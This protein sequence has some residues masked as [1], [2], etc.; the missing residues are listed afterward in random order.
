[1]LESMTLFN[2]GGC[3]LYQYSADPS[4]IK[5]S[6]GSDSATF[7]QQCIQSVVIEPLVLSPDPKT[8]HI[9]NGMTVYWKQETMDHPSMKVYAVAIYPDIL[10]EGPR[11][12][13]KN[14]ANHLLQQTLHEYALYYQ[15][16]YKSHDEDI[17]R[18]DPTLFDPTFCALLLQSKT[19][20]LPANG[21]TETSTTDAPP[22]P[23]ATSATTSKKNEKTQRHWH[24]GKAVVTEKAMAALDKSEDTAGSAEQSHERALREARAAYLPSTEELQQP[25]AATAA[26]PVTLTQQSWI[27]SLFQHVRGTRVIAASDLQQP[28]E[29]M[30]NQLLQKN[31]SST[32][33]QEIACAIEKQLTGQTLNSFYTIQT[34]IQQALEAIIQQIL[35]PKSRKPLDLV[36]NVRLLQQQ[37]SSSLFSTGPSKRRPYVITV[38]GINGIGKT[39]TI[40]KLAYYFSQHQCRPLLVAGDTFRSGAIEQLRV[41]ADCLQ[42][43][44]F[45]QGYSKDPSAVAAAAIAHATQE[46]LPVVLIDTAGRMQNNV[47]L[48]KSLQ[49]LMV[50]N[51]PDCCLFVCEA[52]VGNDGFHQFQ[53]FQKALGNARPV[54]G[55]ILT[56]FDTIDTKVGACL[57][58]TYDCRTPIV[59]LGVGQKYHHLQPLDVSTIIRGLFA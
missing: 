15:Q 8:Y 55:L 53:M 9:T 29:Q 42:I 11:Q 31:V 25:S 45:S 5:N 40:A 33:A 39:T 44:L 30:R 54:D 50:E 36:A 4:L 58:L 16:F 19:Q 49:K 48:M 10:F 52:I 3:V 21:T 23:A 47:P 59:F 37:R 13:L 56:K 51:K 7:T 32:V 14:W 17:P 22:P 6:G 41:H 18:P 26:P 2:A 34:A 12:Y 43:P 35:M 46:Q 38:M 20:R 57:T 1:M 28:L 27:V 24:D